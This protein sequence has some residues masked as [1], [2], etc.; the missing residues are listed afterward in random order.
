MDPVV[1]KA[2]LEIAY[3]VLGL[4]ALS[5]LTFAVVVL[6]YFIIKNW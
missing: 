3:Y 1:V 5:V 6:F 4:V 2:W